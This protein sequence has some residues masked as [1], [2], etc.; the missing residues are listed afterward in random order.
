MSG[1]SVAMI[2]KLL[3][4]YAALEAGQ[5]PVS[6]SGYAEYWGPRMTRRGSSTERR[7]AIRVGSAS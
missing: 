5:M 4:S 2:R 1:Y 7:A 6:D 3:A